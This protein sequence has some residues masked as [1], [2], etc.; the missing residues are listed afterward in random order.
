MID[1]WL[2]DVCMIHD[3]LPSAKLTVCEL[4]NCQ[5]WI[6]PVKIVIF[7]DYVSLPEGIDKINRWMG[8]KGILSGYDQ[9][10]KKWV[11]LG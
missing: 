4:E 7:H 6:D 1:G 5:S 10:P 8:T 9:F 11:E 2:M 3:D